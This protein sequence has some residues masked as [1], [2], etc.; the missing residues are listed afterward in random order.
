MKWSLFKKKQV[1]EFDFDN[2]SKDSNYVFVH[3]PKN[4]GTTISQLLGID[5][6]RHYTVSEYKAMLGRKQ[7]EALF[8]FAIVRNPFSRFLSLYNY[9]RMD[10]SYYHSAIKPE[11]AIYGKHMDYDTLQ[12]ASIAEAALLLKEGKLVHNPPHNQWKPQTFWLKNDVGK[13]DLDFIGRF[14]TLEEDVKQIVEKLGIRPVNA[15]KKTNASKKKGSSYREVIDD[16]TRKILEEYYASDL[17]T[18][19]YE[20]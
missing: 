11:K 19:G 14:E 18:F 16:N 6:S 17:E 15:L 7:Y 5:V 1:P 12:H 2:I 4:A 20:F 10:E 3:V 13:L 9:A 8:S